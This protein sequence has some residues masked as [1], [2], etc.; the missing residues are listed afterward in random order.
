MFAGGEAV[1][2]EAASQL[3]LITELTYFGQQAAYRDI[4]TQERS[5]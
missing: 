1:K 3:D 4:A 2:G 5:D